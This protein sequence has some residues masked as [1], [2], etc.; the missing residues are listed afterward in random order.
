MRLHRRLTPA[1]LAAVLPIAV[2]PAYVALPAGAQ[3]PATPPADSAPAAVAALEHAQETLQGVLSGLQGGDHAGHQGEQHV[4]ATLA[5]LELRKALPQLDRADRREARQLM[6][7]PDVYQDIDPKTS[8]VQDPD[9]EYG[10]A[11]SSAE[12]RNAKVDCSDGRFCV[13]WV[14]A[15]TMPS[16]SHAATQPEVDATI[17]AMKQVWDRETGA[18]AAGGLGYREPLGDGARGGDGLVG[19]T[20]QLDVYLSDTGEDGI[21]GYAVAEGSQ[22]VQTSAGYLVLENDFSEFSDG[23]PAVAAGLRQVTAAHEFFH[24]VQFAYDADESPWLI[25][26]TA[27]W[28]EEQVYDAVDD[29]RAYLADSSLHWPGQSLDIFNPL[30]YEAYGA[31]VFHELLAK[32][33]GIDTIRQAW[34]VAASRQGDNA[35]QAFD[36][37]LRKLGS[38]M[39][40]E[41]RAFSGA[42]MAPA[43]FWPEGRAYPSALISRTWDLGKANR[44]TDWRATWNNHLA[45]TDYRFRPRAGLTSTAWK[46]RIKVDAPSAGGTAYVLVV[47]KDGRIGNYPLGLN[48][49]G[50]RT[51]SFPFSASKVSRV[52]LSV[53]NGTRAWDERKTTFKATIWR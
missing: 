41:F 1:L 46:L 49:E 47:Y 40:D 52:L 14:P 6:A 36:T 13:H 31:W 51:V 20:G 24:L 35:Y 28:M 2:A 27:T 48:A 23:S 25:E 37:V 16:S 7:R 15:E 53:G 12:T 22:A 8:G 34:T 50:N 26:S 29:N 42:A 19:N 43:A 33:R 38:S 17:A 21:F 32:R 45:S 11:W 30:G 5:L 44:S 10:A 39:P 18:P 3:D 4:E 9:N